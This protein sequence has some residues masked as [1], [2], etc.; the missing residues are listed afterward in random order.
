MGEQAADLEI[1]KEV[2]YMQIFGSRLQ[3]RAESTGVEMLSEMMA[4]RD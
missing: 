3:M 4:G 1:K 2:G